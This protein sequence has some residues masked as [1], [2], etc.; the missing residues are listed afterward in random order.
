M[1]YL[2]TGHTGFKGAW[3]ALWLPRLGVHV[4]GMALELAIHPRSFFARVERGVDSHFFDV[5]Q[6]YVVIR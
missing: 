5:R 2:I 1:H 6:P 3:L 4:M